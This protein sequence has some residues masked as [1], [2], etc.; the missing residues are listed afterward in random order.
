VAS[1]QLIDAHL[2]TLAARLPADA[3]DELADGLHETWHHHL[4]TGL[5]PADA[6]RA[7]ITEFGTTEQITDAFV[8]HAPGRRTAALLLATGPV[9]GVCWGASL[10]TAHA[11]TWPIPRP[12]IA[13]FGLALLAVA[14]TLA[15]AATARRSYRRTRLGAAG[16]LGLIILDATM[17]ATV[18]LAAPAL[19]WPMFAAVPVSLARI[20]ITLRSLSHTFA[21]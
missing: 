1:H 17:L 8:R 6:A 10:I 15:I 11:W 18:L 3:V 21:R 19:V 7:A 13:A 4:D 16:S 2:A 12:A 5:T 9:A 14:A 20:T